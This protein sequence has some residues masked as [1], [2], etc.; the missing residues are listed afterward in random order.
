VGYNV[1]EGLELLLYAFLDLP[2]YQRAFPKGKQ[3]E[4]DAAA[5]LSLLTSLWC[6]DVYVGFVRIA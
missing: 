3:F 4:A 5:I 6:D 2:V 1:K